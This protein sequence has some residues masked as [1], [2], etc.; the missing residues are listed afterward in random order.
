MIRVEEESVNKG[1]R[2]ERK[3]SN[4]CNGTLGKLSVVGIRPKGQGG[5]CTALV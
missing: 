5:P 1:K 4:A 3:V 2:K